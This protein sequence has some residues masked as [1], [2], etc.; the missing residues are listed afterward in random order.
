MKK[1]LL[2]MLS[3]FGGVLLAFM[4]IDSQQAQKTSN[5]E[6]MSK[7]EHQQVYQQY[8]DYEEGR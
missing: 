5:A 6:P 3:V 7:E 1:L 4:I 2:N 8:I